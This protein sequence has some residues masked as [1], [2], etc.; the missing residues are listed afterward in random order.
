ML[1]L[2]KRETA[3]YWLFYLLFALLC[4]G[5]ILE[6]VL[7]ARNSAML[8]LS[9]LWAWTGLSALVGLDPPLM[10]RLRPAH[11]RRPY[12]LCALLYLALG[13][14]WC[15]VSFTGLSTRALPVIAVT[16]PFAAA[17]IALSRRA[18]RQDAPPVPEESES[19]C[20]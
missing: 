7:P 11:L 12:R 18:L 8:L 9:I 16:L 6:G 2:I 19:S 4:C 20:L 10:R 17:L 3:L 13:A 5:G 15:G 14:V 1:N